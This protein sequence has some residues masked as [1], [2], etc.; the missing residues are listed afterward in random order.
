MP[1]SPFGGGGPGQ[2]KDGTTEGA[3]QGERTFLPGE[4]AR[5]GGGGP[6]EPPRTKATSAKAKKK[7][8]EPQTFARKKKK[9]KK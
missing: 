9:T 7:K 5:G 2:K 3:R 8:K 1:A 4:T 6:L